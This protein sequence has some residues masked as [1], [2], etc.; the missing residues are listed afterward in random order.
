MSGILPRKNPETLLQ[1]FQNSIR[2]LD[3]PDVSY[4]ELQLVSKYQVIIFLTIF[5]F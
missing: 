2:H 4:D 5:T 1:R 3:L